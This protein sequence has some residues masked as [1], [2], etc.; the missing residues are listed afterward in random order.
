MADFGSTLQTAGGVASLIPGGGLVG[1][2]L[3]LVGGISKLF[4]GKSDYEKNKEELAK[5]KDPFYKI[6]N[7][8]YQNRNLAASQ[9][10]QGLSQPE[11]DYYT[12]ESQRGLG[13]SLNALTQTSSSP[14]YIADIF[15]QYN[16][17]LQSTAAKSAELR[18]A[19][20]MNFY[21]RNK[22]LAGQKTIQWSLNEQQPIQNKRA[23]LSGNMINAKQNQTQGWNDI[24]GSISAASTAFMNR[25][26]PPPGNT[27][28]W[29][30]TYNVDTSTA[31][32]GGSSV[33]GYIPPN[34]PSNPQP[35]IVFNPQ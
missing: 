30:P 21:E 12:T 28:A 31:D 13:S 22:D 25:Q 9:A 6:Q 19:N 5:I 33:G 11:Q 7:E 29:R 16:R 35:S 8:Y 3:G 20:I 14:N 26:A 2:G 4:G 18:R 10:Q 15:D 17:G 34:L 32:A 24:L 1:A 27:D 23:L